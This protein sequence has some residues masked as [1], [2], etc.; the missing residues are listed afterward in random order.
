MADGI[1]WITFYPIAFFAG[2]FVPLQILPAIISRIG[3]WTPLGAA[4]NALQHAIHTG[5]PPAT[6]CSSS[7]ATPSW[8][9]C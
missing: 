8:P 5:F 9:A 1:A 6:P 4:F 2:V 3:D 7:P